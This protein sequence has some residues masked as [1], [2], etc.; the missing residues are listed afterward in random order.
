MAASNLRWRASQWF[1][2]HLTHINAKRASCD[3][4]A[5][6]EVDAW[7]LSHAVAGQRFLIVTDGAL[8]SWK[9]IPAPQ[10]GYGLNKAKDLPD[11]SGAL[12]DEEVMWGECHAK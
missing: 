4:S 3:A 11:S 6:K 12:R 2:A 9:S 1:S 8:R 7:T 10:A 5:G